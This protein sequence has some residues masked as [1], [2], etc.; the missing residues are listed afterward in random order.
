MF[1]GLMLFVPQ[2]ED[3]HIQCRFEIFGLV[4]LFG[5]IRNPKC[6]KI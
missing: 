1:S 6:S 3:L 2:P 4:S 5:K